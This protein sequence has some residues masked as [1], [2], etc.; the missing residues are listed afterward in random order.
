MSVLGIFSSLGIDL[1]AEAAKVGGGLIQL[2]ERVG[3]TA[4]ADVES[5]FKQGVPL[6][7]QAIAAEVPKVISGDEKFGNAV[8][9]VAEQLEAT[10][11]PVVIADVQTLV[12]MTYRG[13]EEI[14]SPR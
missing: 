11:G 9:S 4:V 8:T 13:L 1:A 5:V 2:G 14:G 12:Q 3:E 10:L 6:A 7:V